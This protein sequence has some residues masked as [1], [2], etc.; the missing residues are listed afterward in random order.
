MNSSK[1]AKLPNTL[2]K[3]KVDMNGKPS[4]ADFQHLKK[5]DIVQI[6]TKAECNCGLYNQLTANASEYRVALFPGSPSTILR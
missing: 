5:L 4:E 1:I 3:L 2:V 6:F